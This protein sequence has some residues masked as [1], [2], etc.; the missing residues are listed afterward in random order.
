MALVK[1]MAE[2]E[3]LFWAELMD[4][5]GYDTSATPPPV[6][7][8]WPT[9]GAPDWRITDNV[10]FMQFSE[11]GD[12]YMQAIDSVLEEEGR[13]FVLR[14]ASTRTLQLKLIA[15]GPSCYESLLAVR[16]ALA[17]GR[18]KLR[19][20]KIYPVSGADSVQYVPELFQGRWW[21]RADLSMTFNC[22]MVFSTS[23]NAIEQVDVTIKA[24]EPGSHVLEP[25]D[26]IIKKG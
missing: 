11:V 17:G 18:P 20:Q 16:M 12:G 24:N 13:D 2:L 1:S 4:V 25:G 8:S 19:K 9:D 5:L 23:V 15:Y 14:R 3:A 10:V 22:L 6:R 26:I 21:K 7:R